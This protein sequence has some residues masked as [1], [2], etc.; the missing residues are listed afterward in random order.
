[1][2]RCF[3]DVCKKENTSLTFSFEATLMEV[4]EVFDL[5]QHNLNSKPQ[6]T[7]NKR[8]IHVCEDCYKKNFEELLKI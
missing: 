3:C 4:K 5:T 1:M 6:R 2:L 7:M 8:L